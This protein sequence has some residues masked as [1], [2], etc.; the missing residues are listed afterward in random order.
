MNLRFGSLRTWFP[1]SR[2]VSIGFLA[3][4]FLLLS[5]ASSLSFAQPPGGTMGGGGFGTLPAIGTNPVLTKA[6]LES[7]MSQNLAYTVFCANSQHYVSCCTVGG[8]CSTASSKASGMCGVAPDSDGAGGGPTSPV[9]LTSLAKGA[10]AGGGG[11]MGAPS[12]SM[13]VN[14][15]SH[16]LHVAEDF[17][18]PRS[19]EA[20]GGCAT[21]AEGG[22]G[23]GGANG[24]SC[25]DFQM[26]RQH[27]G[28][29][30]PNSP[31]SAPAGTAAMI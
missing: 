10:A 18:R 22:G 24:G 16:S 3:L 17:A 23:D 1:T 31:V 27:R 25:L 20:G 8:P 26:I 29:T 15:S 30:K 11:R 7:A 5:V 19:P 2:F 28:L 6:Q 4:S 14:V 12:Q 9:P 13:T 21:C